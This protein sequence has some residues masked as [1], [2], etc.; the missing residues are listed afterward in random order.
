MS[1]NT[2][3]ITFTGSLTQLDNNTFGSYFP[4]AC[5]TFGIRPFV[6]SQAPVVPEPI[7]EYDFNNYIAT[8]PT[9]VDNKGGADATILLEMA[10]S[11]DATNPTNKFL[12]IYSPPPIDPADPTGGI[13]LPSLSGVKAIEMWVNYASWDGYGQYVLDARTGSPVGY[14]IT[15]GDTIGTDWD[16][17]KFYNNTLGTAINSTAGTPIIADA[18]A[19]LGWRQLFFLTPTSTSIADDIALFCRYTGNQGMPI[20]V[21]YIGI[22][23]VEPTSTDVISIFNS[24]CSRYGLS[25]V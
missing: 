1:N 12:T 7:A 19:G 11:F 16:N 20:S 17:G 3:G 10:N 23:D 8:S 13:V 9:L 6:S 21:A 4:S 15:K 5:N 25:P 24:K 2:F 22:Y 14:W 18:I